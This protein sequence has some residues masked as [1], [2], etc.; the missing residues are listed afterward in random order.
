MKASIITNTLEIYKMKIRVEAKSGYFTHD[1]KL[2]DSI[3]KSHYKS[4][5]RL[6]TNY[7]YKDKTGTISKRNTERFLS[8]VDEIEKSSSKVAK[9]SHAKSKANY[10]T[11][12]NKQKMSFEEY[13][14]EYLDQHIALMSD[15]QKTD[16]YK[17]YTQLINS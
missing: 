15:T 11:K 4:L 12:T 1:F 7:N 16:N 2:I 10:K 8:L 17:A 9:Q 3:C 5:M 6:A 14:E 13:C